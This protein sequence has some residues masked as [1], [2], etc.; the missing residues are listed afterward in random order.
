MVIHTNYF[1]SQVFRI[2]HVNLFKLWNNVVEKH[3][4]LQA[5]SIAVLVVMNKC[6]KTFVRLWMRLLITWCVSHVD[7]M[8][9]T[10]VIVRCMKPTKRLENH[11]SVTSVVFAM[12]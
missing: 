11:R 4:D 7:Y 5:K 1:T 3:W 6:M 12:W 9:A 2:N 10:L 8:S